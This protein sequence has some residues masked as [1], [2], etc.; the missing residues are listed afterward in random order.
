MHME[1]NR[2]LKGSNAQLPQRRIW[3][4]PECPVNPIM[5]QRGMLFKQALFTVETSRVP[6]LKSRW[7]KRKKMTNYFTLWSSSSPPPPHNLLDGLI[8]LI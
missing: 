1:S 2:S 6:D 3:L 4:Y 5:E 7:Q 8:S